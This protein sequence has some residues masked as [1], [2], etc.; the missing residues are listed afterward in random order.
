MGDFVTVRNHQR[1]RNKFASFGYYTTKGPKNSS[2]YDANPFYVVSAE[3][4]S[5]RR[6]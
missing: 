3:P 5:V 1:N 2:Q 6:R 4:H